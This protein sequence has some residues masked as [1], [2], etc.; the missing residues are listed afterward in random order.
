MFDVTLVTENRLLVSSLM[1]VMLAKRGW[2][3]KAASSL[4]SAW[5]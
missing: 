3:V 2:N 4:V 5:L 1:L